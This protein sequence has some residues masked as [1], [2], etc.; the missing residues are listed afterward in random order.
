M[1]VSP[2][3]QK[4]LLGGG[5]AQLS[6]ADAKKAITSASAP[7]TVCTEETDK[8]F[9]TVVDESG[10]L[11]ES[12]VVKMT[13]HT[14][15]LTQI[16]LTSGF[17]RPADGT[18]FDSGSITGTRKQ[19][20]SQHLRI[21]LP[22][23]D[24]WVEDNCEGPEVMDKLMTMAINQAR[25][26][27]TI[28]ALMASVSAGGGPF[29]DTG[30]MHTPTMRL[31]DGWYAEMRK[32]SPTISAQGDTDR[33]ISECKLKRLVQ[34]LPNKYKVNR[35]QV[36]IYMASDLWEDLVYTRG[37]RLTPLGDLRIP[38]V[39]PEKAFSVPI[40]P[41]SLLP[42]DMTSCSLGSVSPADATFMFIT[43]KGNL[44]LGIQ[45]ELTYERIRNCPGTT[46]HIWSLRADA[47]VLDYEAAVLY[48]CLAI[49]G[50]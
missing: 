26:E 19:L 37:Q 43:P 5:R 16:G 23:D 25:N 4:A 30:A 12:T 39:M 29:Y 27:L 21:H 36:R 48:D 15:D 44:I 35:D 24:E 1:R 41:V 40:V 38:D 9:Q 47:L 46:T 22:I 10:F 14:K 42:I 31:I 50:C 7:Y 34:R 13:Q 6:K 3:A 45:R 8:F 2:L 20:I 18:C 17:L 33:F 32:N 28:F 11:K 49:R